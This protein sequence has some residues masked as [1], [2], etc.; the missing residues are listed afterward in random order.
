MQRNVIE[1]VL[2]AVVL[3]VAFLFLLFAYSI[4]RSTVEGYEVTAAFNDLG[5]I[6]TGDTVRISG[7][8]VGQ[9]KAIK[10]DQETF[11]ADV[12]F[13]IDPTIQ[14]PLDTIAVI[15]SDGLLGGKFISLEIGGDL[16]NIPPGGRID[17][18]QSTPGFE[19]LLG[20][21]IYNL[22]SIGNDSE[23]TGLK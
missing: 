16:E 10:L 2:G 13:I 5:G 23:S 14:L 21:V 15:S 7:V 11:L 19:Q 18:T 22:Q 3:I 4:T 8:D 17:F 9:I 20:Q 12:S 6:Q 1:V